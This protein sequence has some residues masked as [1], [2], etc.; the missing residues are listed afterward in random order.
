ML[1]LLL[2]LDDKTT[3]MDRNRTLLS[4]TLSLFVWVYKSQGAAA[5][6]DEASSGSK[7]RNQPTCLAVRVLASNAARKA[8]IPASVHAFP[9]AS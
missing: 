2:M 1:T 6:L 4:R 7:M 9:S 8:S 3:A 5:G